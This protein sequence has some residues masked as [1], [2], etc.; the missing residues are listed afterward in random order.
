[1]ARTKQT[2]R[3]STTPADAATTP[4]AVATAV[5]VGGVRKSSSRRFLAGEAFVGAAEPE[6]HGATDRPPP[7]PPAPA[8]ATALLRDVVEAAVDIATVLPRD[9]VEAAVDRALQAQGR[10]SG[11]DMDDIV[12]AVV[13]DLGVDEA[14]LSM[15]RAAI[16]A[17]VN[18]HLLFAATGQSSPSPPPPPP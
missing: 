10:S 16:S 17:Y 6:R 13:R 9:V 14:Q 12:A 5:L 4:A 3:R 15:D 18:C 2:A 11:F 8:A 7:E 1:M